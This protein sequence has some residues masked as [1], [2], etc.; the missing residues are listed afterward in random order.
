MTDKINLPI[1]PEQIEQLNPAEYAEF[2]TRL[3]QA[4]PADIVDSEHRRNLRQIAALN[5][6]ME[7]Y[8][9]YYELIH[10]AAMV[11][12]NLPAIQKEYEAW[13]NGQAFLWFGFRGC[14]KTSSQFTLA[15]FLHGHHPDGTGVIVGANDGNSKLI[16]KSIA[17]IIELH[18][19]FKA[20]FPHIQINKSRGWGAEGYWIRD[21]RLTAE[22]WAAKMAKVNDPSFIGGGYGSSE[23]NG[24][25][26]T[27]Y[28]FADD[29]HDID[30]SG[31][32][33]ER[34]RIKKVFISQ[35]L[36]T[37]VREND[38]L[39]TRVSMTGVPFAKDDT[40]HVMRDSGDVMFIEIPVMRRAAD[41]AAGAVYIDGKNPVTG[42]IY[43]DIVG[44]WYLTWPESWGVKSILSER[45]KGRGAFWQMMMLDINIAKTAGLVY[46][47]YD[48]TKI[49]FDLPTGGGADATSLD[50][51]VEVG[52]QKRSSFALAYV[53]KL[54]DGRLVL[55][56]GVLKPMGIVKAREA[57]LQ[58]Q[59]MFRN[60]ITTA[61]E[62][63]GPGKI[64]MQFLRLDSRVRFR[65][66]NIADPHG[67][68]KDKKARFEGQVHPWLESG[69]LL[70]SDEDNEYC[71]AVRYLC[72]NFFD[73]A[74]NK[75]HEALDAGDGLY[76]AL[77]LFP[78]VLRFPSPGSMNPNDMM[79]QQRQGLYHPFAHIGDKDARRPY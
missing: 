44:W 26:P 12:H 68:I 71:L 61:V 43:D 48:H 56:G 47:L 35:I 34:E 59:T 15:S 70:I 30:S 45:A 72:D 22:E 8:L 39:K 3:A 62:N 29:L 16:A 40:Y 31:S 27:L 5:D 19:E 7:S 4:L 76:Q 41:N 1:T 52:G 74:P 57:I 2:I 64:L 20:V 67:V 66:S 10:G 51:D 79:N 18:P 53:C 32:V 60:W 24:K 33:T 23:I 69:Y 54:T 13:E 78:E 49:G 50:P 75:P 37:A 46:Y 58:A 65:D 25:H 14:R 11:E 17:Q 36:K 73:I 42:A 55:K 6:G 21:D 38:V 63:T 77:K 28:L 9:A